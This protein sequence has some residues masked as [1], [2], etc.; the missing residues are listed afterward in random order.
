MAERNYEI[1]VIGGDGVGPEIVEA[2][3]E[4]LTELALKDGGFGLSFTSYD[5]GSNYYRQH[6]LMMPA[7]GLSQLER[8]DAIYFGSVGDPGLPGEITLWGLRLAICQGFDQYANMR[9]ARLLPG[10]PGPLRPEL[11]CEVDWVIVRENSEGEYSGAGGR[12][13]Q[14]LPLE[15]GMDVSVFTRAG[16]ERIARYACELALTRTRQKLTIVTKSDAQRHGM[17]LWDD[18]CEEVLLDYPGLEVD[19][20][21]A[22]GMAQRMVLKPWSIDTVLATNLHADVLSELA[23]AL[24][25]SP[26]IGASADLDPSRNRP[27]MFAPVLGS[28]F[29]IAGKGAANP[30]GAFWAACLMLGHLGE[31]A[32]SQ[33]LMEAIETV[34]A[35]G[36]TLPP[37]LGGSA[38]TQDVTRAVIAEFDDST[39]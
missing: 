33:R 3:R 9:P 8:Y 30:L 2:G 28:A 19:W 6:G 27:S 20:E 14:G 35:L 13:H 38:S 24:T 29:D 34:T 23:V 1:A 26:G 25:G 17:V 18:V 21:A 31:P 39:V 37:D 12:V 16:V 4:V 36:E 15:L 32:A 22:N 11:A 5:W 7:D 10:I